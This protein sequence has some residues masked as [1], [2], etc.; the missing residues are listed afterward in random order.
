MNVCKRVREVIAAALEIEVHLL[1][2]DSGLNRHPAWDSLNH[3][4]IIASLEDSFG[5]QF[6]DE[7]VVEGVDAP[8]LIT[9]IEEKIQGNS[10]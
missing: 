10:P 1:R 6:D 4:A 8:T 3:V 9:L 5:V 7:D 2:D